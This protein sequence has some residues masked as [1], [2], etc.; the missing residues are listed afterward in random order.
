MEFGKI[1]AFTFSLRSLLVFRM[2]PLVIDTPPPTPLMGDI[3]DLASPMLPL[4]LRRCANPTLLDLM[5]RYGEVDS[6][7]RL[8][9]SFCRAAKY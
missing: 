2:V 5:L 7:M 9:F 8:I 4:V 1:I 3:L 6:S